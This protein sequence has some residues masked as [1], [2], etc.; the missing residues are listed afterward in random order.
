M[1]PVLAI[2]AIA[3][4]SAAL[5]HEPLEFGGDRQ[6]IVLTAEETGGAMG[7]FSVTSDDP[8]GPPMHVHHDADEAFYIVEGNFILAVGEERIEVGPGAH[9]LRHSR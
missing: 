6:H 2:L 3:L 1:K 9:A 7:M 5:A 4:P 8:G